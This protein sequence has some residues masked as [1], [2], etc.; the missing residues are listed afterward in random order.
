MP[1]DMFSPGG[2]CPSLVS[3]A[4]NIQ[5]VC[6]DFPLSYSLSLQLCTSAVDSSCTKGK[7]SP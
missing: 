2:A 3:E 5:H 1:I 4:I 7:K 6:R